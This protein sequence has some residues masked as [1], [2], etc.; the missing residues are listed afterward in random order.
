M[1]HVRD[2]AKEN[3]M[4]DPFLPENRNNPKDTIHPG[5]QLKLPGQD[6]EGKPYEGP[7]PPG[8]P[9]EAPPAKPTDGPVAPKPTDVPAPKTD[10]PVEVPVD[11]AKAKAELD[12]EK[13]RLDQN[14][15]KNHV[16]AEDQQ[17]IHDNMKAFEDRAAKD[18]LPPDE[19]AK[20]Y[21]AANKLYES[22]GDQPIP[23]ADKAVLADQIIAHAAV[24]TRIDQ[25][26]HNT[27][28]PSSLESRLFTTHPSDAAKLIS[29][30]GTTGSYTAKDGTKVNLDAN[31]LKKDNEAGNNPPK[32]NERSYASK[33]FQET[34]LDLHFQAKGEHFKETPGSVP[35]DRSSYGLKDKEQVVDSHGRSK[36]FDGVTLND[37]SDMETKITGKRDASHYLGNHEIYGNDRQQ[38]G[39]MTT[40]KNEAEFKQALTDAKKNGEMPLTVWVDS[41]QPPF[42][43]GQQAGGGGGGHFVSITDYDDKTGKV[44]V[45]NQ[46]GKDADHLGDNGVPLH[47]MFEATHPP[48]ANQPMSINTQNI[49]RQ[50]MDVTPNDPYFYDLTRDKQIGRDN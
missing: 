1:N 33:L 48:R 20:T 9:P 15:E 43:N 31:D 17:R 7:K 4:P 8:A 11:P 46:W 39:K 22:T 5:Q 38:A 30:V 19:V 37:L 32:D 34:A 40:F 49:P 25:G 23:K 26:Q 28:G 14:M 27:C 13:Q 16:S 42:G 24:P 10:K 3:G 44:S 18:K 2:I 36:D 6:K 12:A 50:R 41:R 47:E 35:G 45:D 21:E 29:D